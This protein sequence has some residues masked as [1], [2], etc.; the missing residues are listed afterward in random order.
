MWTYDGKT[1]SIPSKCVYGIVHS[2]GDPIAFLEVLMVWDVW[3]LRFE[4]ALKQRNRSRFTIRVYVLELGAFFRFLEEEGVERLEDVTAELVQAYRSAIFH[5]RW[6]GRPLAMK[7]QGLKLC[8]LRAF[9]RTMLRAHYLLTD[10]SADLEL[11]R[12]PPPAL[13]ELLSEAEMLRLLEGLDGRTRL[14]LRDRAILEI[15]Y[16]TGIRNQELRALRL[17]DVDLVRGELTVSGKG[18]KQRRLPL[19]EEAA[20]R[21]EAYLA[22]RHTRHPSPLLF[23]TKRGQPLGSCALIN[24]VQLA[25]DQAGLNRRV[26]PHLVRHSCATHMLRGGAELRHLQCLLGH[27]SVATTQRYTRVELSDLRQM[28]QRCHPRERGLSA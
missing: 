16:S 1:E 9:F 17:E 4:E 10:P 11:P 19:G 25:A 22:V 8:A 6:Q 5:R 13:P 27:A 28:H 23:L 18:G 7:T 15:L 14:E 26:T 20:R 2:L 21:L 3:R 12:V 24:L